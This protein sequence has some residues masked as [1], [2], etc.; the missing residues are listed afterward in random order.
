MVDEG[1]SVTLRVAEAKTRD[2]GRG[3]A[4]IDPQTVKE[5]G[6]HTGDV[7]QIENIAKLSKTAAILWPSFPEDEGSGLIRI[8]GSI[9]DNIKIA[10]DKRV[11]VRKIKARPA[12]VVELAPIQSRFVVRNEQYFSQLLENRVVTQGDIVSFMVMGSRIELAVTN[13]RPKADAVIITLQTKVQV[14]REQVSDDIKNRSKSRVCFEDIGGL[15]EEI[16]KIREMIELPLRHPEI[17]VRIGIAPPKGVLLYGPP[18]TGKTLLGRAVA[19]ETDANFINLSGPE[20]VSRFYGASEENLRKL[21]KDAQER[22]PSI[23]FID[24]FDSIAPRREAITGEVERRV[25]AQL[26]SLMDGL[27]SRG[28]VIV[29]GATNRPDAIDPAFRQAGR[30]DREIELKVPNNAG[31]FEILQIHV[32]SSPLADDV[33]LKSLADQTDGFVGADLHSLVK[34]AAM[35]AVRRILPEIKLDEPVP[36]E[37]LDRIKITMMDFQNALKEIKITKEHKISSVPPT[38][39]RPNNAIL[40][41]LE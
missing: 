16:A 6:L 25:V 1:K 11:Q 24:E 29:I 2:F 9:R 17:F 26:L 5:L 28:E 13:F 12:E 33:D 3:I 34:E 4:R 39:S 15:G 32:R 8:D 14:S 38:E 41:N 30:F 22:A 21:F 20:I 37:I 35:H 23:I 40:K 10:I 7:V 27:E 18:G 19:S 36:P 31:R